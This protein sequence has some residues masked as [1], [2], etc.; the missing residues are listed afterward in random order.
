MKA[1][2]IIDM[3][4]GFTEPETNKGKCAL[5][6]PDAKGLIPNINR[7]IS[8]LRRG[9][10]RLIFVR[11]SHSDNDKEFE[12]FPKHCLSGTEEAKSADG[13]EHEG[14]MAHNFPKTRFSALFGTPIE[15][16]L[17][18]YENIEEVIVTGVCTEICILFTVA[19]LRMRDY[20]VVVPRDCVSGLTKEGHEWALNHME[21]ILG[22]EIR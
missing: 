3:I 15:Y 17:S 13:F 20:G 22:A 12:M 19:D 10:D 14:I 2:L 18:E 9:V 6:L 11:D 8:K 5:Y 4:K 1:L 16:L 21:K 7:E